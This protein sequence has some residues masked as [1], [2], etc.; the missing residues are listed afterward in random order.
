MERTK[1][2]AMS[3]TQLIN[4]GEKKEFL[5]SLAKHIKNG[6]IESASIRLETL[7][8]E[9]KLELLKDYV[10]ENT[11]GETLLHLAVKKLDNESFI[12]KLAELCP[13]LP[14]TKI[15]DKKPLAGQTALHITITKGNVVL[16]KTLLDVVQQKQHEEMSSLLHSMATGGRFVNTV[17]MGQLPLTVAALTGNTEIVDLLLEYGANLHDQNEKGDT[18]FHS[19]VKYAAIYPEKVM[20]II[21]M[22]QYLNQELESKYQI[23]T[24]VY[25]N[26]D[27]DK[28]RHIHSFVW[29]MKNKE[30]MTTL[31]LAAQ[32]GVFQLF[33]EIINIRNVYCFIR[34]NDGLY[35]VKEYDIT[36]ID[37]VS[38][39]LTSDQERARRAA[40]QQNQKTQQ[41]EGVSKRKIHTNE[42]PCA[43]CS[44][45]SN[46]NSESVLEMLFRYDYDRKDAYR[47]IEL[48]PVK[49]I[50]KMKWDSYKWVFLMLMILHYLFM[51]FFTIYSVY[52]VEV[53][54]QS[55]SAGMYI[56][57][58]GTGEDDFTSYRST[59]M[60]MFKLGIGINDI[61]VLNSARIPWVAVT[62][63]IVFTVFTYLLMLNA[64]IAMMSQ[65]CSLVL[66]ERFPQWRIQ[67]LS[68]VLLIE[69][70]FWFC[71]FGY[72]LSCEGKSITSMGYDP[73]T[74]TMKGEERFV[75]EIHSLQMEYATP[76]DKTCIKKKSAEIQT[77]CLQSR[78]QESLLRS[79]TF[80]NPLS[81]NI[82]PARQSSIYT[83]GVQASG[84]LRQSFQPR[85]RRMKSK[86]E[87]K[88]KRLEKL[89]KTNTNEENEES[90][91]F[92]PV[93][94]RVRSSK[95]P[96][97]VSQM[98]KSFSENG[99]ETRN[100][101]SP[102][103]DIEPLTC[104]LNLA[105]LPLDRQINAKKPS[106]YEIWNITDS[107]T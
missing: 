98:G 78:A 88:R 75:L 39:V 57:F 99:M 42:T 94:P 51:I 102:V 35:D 10:T 82:F 50:I 62:I 53:G 12:R 24:T 73:L 63:F 37:T 14:I 56:V 2:V 38:I 22:L 11:Q 106:E 87:K 79:Q 48:T 16:T 84:S 90:N 49:N 107:F 47:I 21:Q 77:L 85:I 100:Q 33:E 104:R 66:E 18:V 95:K 54:I 60:A 36:E 71:C 64:L 19:L 105:R 68:I 13:D 7:G 29:F 92:R 59:M 44:C 69:D 55:V 32:H 5:L 8:R 41:F 52:I 25:N 3:T 101:H 34:E 97:L 28:C 81:S 30:N 4:S 43:P 91:K 20:A 6:D 93:S 89:D 15:E 65:T 70:I 83:T 9:G 1:Y 45:C 61:S 31:Q 17:M 72:K 27:E 86:K 58:R 26:S 67:Q 46:L 74:R 76:E 80:T 96:T 103:V 23:D 40:S